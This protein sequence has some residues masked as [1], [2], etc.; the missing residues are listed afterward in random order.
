[1]EIPKHVHPTQYKFRLR[2]LFQVISQALFRQGRD[3]AVS[4][5]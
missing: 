1:M 5:Q 3:V 4:Y 2:R